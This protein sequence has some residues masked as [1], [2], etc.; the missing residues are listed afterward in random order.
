MYE[1]G[2]LLVREERECMREERYL[3]VRRE[4]VY[5]RG[6]GVHTIMGT[7]GMLEVRKETIKR[8]III[9]NINNI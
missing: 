6:E 2:E 9:Y 8:V 4:R 3:C 7:C 1:R 5:E